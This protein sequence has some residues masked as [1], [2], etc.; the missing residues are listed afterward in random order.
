MRSFDRTD[1]RGAQPRAHRPP[2][3]R[4][5][6]ARRATAVEN[7]RARA[8]PSAVE[9]VGDVMADVTL[10]TRAARRAR[11]TPARAATAWRPAATCSSR[12]TG[13]ATSTTPSGW[14][15]W[16]S[17]CWALPLPALL[18]LHPR[19]RARLQ[20]AGLRRA[21][22]RGAG[23]I[24]H[25]CRR[26][27][28]STSCPAVPRA[29]GADRLRRRAEGGLPGGRSLRHAARARPSG[30]RRSSSAGT[31]SW[32]STRTPR[33]GGARA[34]ASRRAPRALRRRP[35]RRG[36]V[37]HCA[38]EPPRSCL[39]GTAAE[40]H[41]SGWSAR[42]RRPA[43][44]RSPSRRRAAASS[45]ST[46]TRAGSRRC[47]RPASPTSRTF[48]SASSP[49]GIRDLLERRPRDYGAL[50]HA[51]AIA[52]LRPDAADRQPRARPAAR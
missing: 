22:A 23:V 11:R 49:G 47:W 8:W 51:D 33:A 6:C 45:A 2:R 39:A 43:R 50:A 41:A 1:A 16:S 15:A 24:L 44:W 7:L 40:T 42:L 28:T 30:S 18:P 29:R 19:T 4:C 26:S 46:S 17:C 31:G 21:P 36:R 20:A 38:G 3:P 5:C 27:G 52:D 37:V 14:A 13:P 48:R 12:R 9:L 35:G 32:T 10:M 34:S 25:R